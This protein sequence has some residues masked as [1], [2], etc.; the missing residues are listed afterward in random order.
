MSVLKQTHGNFVK[1]D[2]LRTCVD[3]HGSAREHP[4]F[5][6]MFRRARKH[7]HTRARALNTIIGIPALPD[8]KVAVFNNRLSG[9]HTICELK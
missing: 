1:H 7:T 9:Q 8:L 3:V 5:A 6:V 2:N 4:F